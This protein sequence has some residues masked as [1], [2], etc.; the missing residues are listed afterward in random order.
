[1][2]VVTNGRPADR[3]PM[4][5]AKLRVRG[6]AQA[7]RPLDTEVPRPRV[8]AAPFD[9]AQSDL[10]RHRANQAEGATA[11]STSDQFGRRCSGQLGAN[12]ACTVADPEQRAL[13]SAG[14]PSDPSEV[15][16]P[17]ALP[18]PLPPV[19]VPVQLPIP[20]QVPA[21][22]HD[23]NPPAIP[24]KAGPERNFH[25]ARSLPSQDYQ[26]PKKINVRTARSDGGRKSFGSPRTLSGKGFSGSFKGA[27][28]MGRAR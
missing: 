4:S 27:G 6:S 23:L 16:I 19:N 21:P 11:R 15:S 24:D 28:K 7:A 10:L 1:M 26:V 22:V 2:R 18:A 17:V 25:T 20:I 5:A 14:S 13:G 3:V 9:N 12:N 8:E